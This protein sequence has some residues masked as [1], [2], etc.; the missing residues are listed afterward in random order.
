ML[1][2]TLTL[3][4]FGLYAGRQT[5][6]VQTSSKGKK[7]KPIV[8]IGGKNGAGKTSFLDAVRLTLYGKLT[9]G[10]RTS[11]TAYELYLRSR[12]HTGSAL[13]A[14][15]HSASVELEFDFSEA[16]VVHTYRVCRTWIARANSV[17]ESLDV[18]KDGD[19]ITA[20]P[21]DEWHNFL[22][23]LLP[24]GVSQLFFFDG[25]KITEIAED[26]TD[27]QQLSAAIRTLLGI[28]MV[29]RLRTDLGLYLARNQRVE[30]DQ[31]DELEKILEGIDQLQLEL[32]EMINLRADL[33]TAL[34][35]QRRV[36]DR[37]QQRFT[38]AGGE[39]AL[40][41]TSLQ[42]EREALSH[43]RQ[44]LL[45]QFREGSAHLWPWLVAP[46]L[47]K[48]LSKILAASPDTNPK[49]GEA[50]LKRF[51]AWQKKAEPSAK[52]RWTEK[53]REELATLINA[54]FKPAKTGTTCPSMFSGISNAAEVLTQSSAQQHT[55]SMFAAR[56]KEVDRR[57]TDIDVSFARVDETTSS[58]LLDELRGAEQAF[59]ETQ[60]RLNALQESVKALQYRMTVLG[61]DRERIL[62]K[63]AQGGRTSR[64]MAIAERVAASLATYEKALVKQKTRA[65]EVAFVDCFNRLARKSDLVRSVRI[66][67]VTFQ[68]TLVGESGD[69]VSRVRLSA[70]EK[71]VFAIAMLWALAKTSGRSLPV[72]I[73]TPLARLD[74]DHRTA[75]LER[76]LPE[77][78][79]Q[80]IVLSTDTEIDENMAET[81]VPFIAQSLRLDY[82]P[83]EGRTVVTK[84]YFQKSAQRGGVHAIQ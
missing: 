80:V 65:L 68:A 84:G 19:T 22:Q 1:I 33:H 36:A 28:D 35:G 25:E 66:D 6:D 26:A 56:L 2:R 17:A 5:I 63:Q 40:N 9:L 69:E 78:S 52:R 31:S 50:L 70:G 75:I 11:Q 72:I 3:E 18:W 20:I 74:S 21:K 58:F 59:G 53:H 29:G 64:Q 12:I 47:L 61:R 82:L 24:F 60:G 16:G 76:Y 13:G 32:N 77:V 67:D 46:K 49:I 10:E 23:E 30:T 54:T 27:G 62:T 73:D 81:L 15:P 83:G 37:A 57:L 8:L 79:H 48:N 55:V 45:A 38:A 41:R 34:D 51:D 4:N 43:V 42:A 71:Q 14:S 7:P 44:A 39:V